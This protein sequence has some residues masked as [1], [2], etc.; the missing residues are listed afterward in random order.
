M[1][2]R[3]IAQGFNI[4]GVYIYIYEAHASFEILVK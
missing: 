2:S 3:P 4:F 1:A